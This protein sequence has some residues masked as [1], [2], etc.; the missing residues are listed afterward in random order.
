MAEKAKGEK[1]DRNAIVTKWRAFVCRYPPDGMMEMA[2]IMGKAVQHRE[3]TWRKAYF[4]VEVQIFGRSDVCLR[5]PLFLV[6]PAFRSFFPHLK[7]RP[8]LTTYDDARRNAH[9]VFCVPKSHPRKAR[10]TKC[11]NYG[12]LEI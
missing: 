6:F 12:V 1:A 8:A 11:S 5:C 10:T 2:G 3:Q 7:I 9:S 4:V